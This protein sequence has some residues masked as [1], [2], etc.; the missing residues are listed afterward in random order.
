MTAGEATGA[1]FGVGIG[2]G[3]LAAIVQWIKRHTILSTDGDVVP[4]DV[5]A[6]ADRDGVDPDVYALARVAAS[7]AGGQKRIAKAA[8]CWVVMNEA[9]RRGASPLLV[10]LG[11]GTAFGGQGTG[12]R[13]FVSSSHDPQT[14]DLEVAGGVWNRS[15][16][17]PTDG[18]L[19]FDSPHAY[20]D[21]IGDDGEVVQTATER[22]DAF[23]ANRA[24]EG[25][26]LVT[27]EGVPES[28]FRFWRRA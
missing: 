20:R 28:T 1:V 7:E 5:Q 17:D 24:N 10:V 12:G 4:A 27:L 9:A 2:A 8:V 3:L 26:E 22:V 14:V 21:K 6:L 13:G 25:K 16:A 19:N 18:A 23:A 11:S 15:I